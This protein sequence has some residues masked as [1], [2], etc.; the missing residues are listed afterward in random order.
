MQGNQDQEQQDVEQISNLEH[1][2]Y[3]STD[4]NLAPCLKKTS[5]IYVLLR[6]SER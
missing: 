3:C 6:I 2:K 1:S 4:R 5:L